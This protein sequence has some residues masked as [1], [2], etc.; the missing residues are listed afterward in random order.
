MATFVFKAMDLAGVPAQGEVEAASKQDVA[1]Q[2]KER[3]L[4]VVDIAN[5]YRSKEINLELFARVK[6]QGPRGRLAPALDD[7]HLRN[8]DPPR[9]VRA[10]DPDRLEAAEGRRSSRS[11]RTSRPGLLLSDALERHPK[12]FS[13]LY[14]AM[15]R[16]GEAGGV[17]EECLL[18]VADQLEKDAALRRQVRSAM[19]YPR[20]RHHLRGDRAA[21]ARRVPHP[22]V[23][24]RV[25]AVPGQ[26]AGAQSVHGQLLAPADQAVVPDAARRSWRS[27]SAFVSWKRSKWGGPSWDASSCAFR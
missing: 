13:P 19:I 7:G 26:A 16:A 21:G 9:A 18:R 24:G 3:G 2:L 1:E 15:V 11:A 20:A 5:K 27:W 22:G 4:I 14:V 17:L 6:R 25:Q 10:G 8:V 12:V 23:R